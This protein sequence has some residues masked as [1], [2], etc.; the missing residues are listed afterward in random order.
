MPTQAK[1]ITPMA[2]KPQG[3]DSV[4]RSCADGDFVNCNFC[5]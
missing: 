2:T 4:A 1:A 3:Q 5:A